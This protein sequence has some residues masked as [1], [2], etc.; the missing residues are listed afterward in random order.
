MELQPIR[1]FLALRDIFQPSRA[2]ESRS[3]S[4]R[5]APRSHPGF[6]QLNYFL[7][8]SRTLNFASAAGLCGV[9]EFALARGIQQIEEELGGP[10]LRRGPSGMHLSEL[11][12]MM[13]PLFE[14]MLDESDTVKS[15]KAS[16]LAL[17]ETPLK[18]GVMGTI[19][20]MRTMAFVSEFGRA[21]PGVTLTLL[22]GPLDRLTELL[23][24][25][26]ITCALLAQPD[27]FDRRLKAVP[28]YRERFVVAFPLGHRFETQPFVVPR[29]LAG[30]SYLRHLDYGFQA[31]LEALCQ[32]DGVTLRETFRSEREEWI[33]TMVAAGM[34]VCFLPEFSPLVP[35]LSTRPL[36][37][38]EMV[39]E[40]SLVTV[41][42]QPASRALDSFVNAA[43]AYPWDAAIIS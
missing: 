33:Q 43:G 25:G 22:E 15:T 29:D 4:R 39:R 42:G 6:D 10:L 24:D 30:E 41:A 21:N 40:V 27:P 35:G 5:T 11:G 14:R 8:L 18:L 7:A 2:V 19:G 9:D 38:P 37:H 16:F 31:Q 13:R 1:Y 26:V 23:L 32:D 17:D 20:P 28:L 12:R 34:G 3:S 36:R